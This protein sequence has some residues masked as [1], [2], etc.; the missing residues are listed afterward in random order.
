MWCAKRRYE[1]ITVIAGEGLPVQ[2]GHPGVRGLRTGLLRVV[3]ARPVHAGAR[4]AWL[5]EQIHAVHVA[6]RGTYGS[7]RVHAELT[8]AQAS[9]SGT[10]SE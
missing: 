9:P 8:L 10:V 5:N 4:P 3:R 7:R 6:S 1:A 2:L